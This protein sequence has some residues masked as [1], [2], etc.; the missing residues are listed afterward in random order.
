[1]RVRASRAPHGTHGRAT[2]Q[3]AQRFLGRVERA[4][5]GHNEPWFA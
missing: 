2:V 5:L 4:A 3:E 1:M